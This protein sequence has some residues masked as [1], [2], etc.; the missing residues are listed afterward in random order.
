MDNNQ[1]PPDKPAGDNGSPGGAPGGSN[2]NISHSG[3]TTLSE[4]A[5]VNQPSYSSTPGGQNA[6]LVTGG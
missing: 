3:A 5:T 1:T 4:S 2:A 6:L